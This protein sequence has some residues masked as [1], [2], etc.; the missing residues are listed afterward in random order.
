[1]VYQQNIKSSLESRLIFKAIF[2]NNNQELQKSREQ[3]FQLQFLKLCILLFSWQS[4]KF[5]KFNFSTDKKG[6]IN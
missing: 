5:N 1:M 4:G 6:Q 3:C 2:T